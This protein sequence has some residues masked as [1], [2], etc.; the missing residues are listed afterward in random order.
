MIGNDIVRF[1]RRD[2]TGLVKLPWVLVR[3]SAYEA[4]LQQITEGEND[5]HP[6]II[7]TWDDT[8]LNYKPNQLVEK[9]DDIFIIHTHTVGDWDATTK[10]LIEPRFAVVP[11]FV[12][13]KE[14]DQE[15]LVWYDDKMWINLDHVAG[16]WQE[17]Y[18]IQAQ[19]DLLLT[20]ITFYP[21][22]GSA[23]N[24]PFTENGYIVSVG[25]DMEPVMPPAL[26][27]PTTIDV[28]EQ[29]A[30][31][32]YAHFDFSDKTT[33]F[34]DTAK[35]IPV[36]ADGDQ[37][38]VAVSVSHDSEN[39]HE[40]TTTDPSGFFATYKEDGSG[41]GYLDFDRKGDVDLDIHVPW[42]S[43]LGYAGLGASVTV[44]TPSDVTNVQA[45]TRNISTMTL[46]SLN[47]QID[48]VAGL[49]HGYDAIAKAYDNTITTD[50]TEFFKGSDSVYWEIFSGWDVSQVEHF[51]YLFEDS[52]ADM[53][54]STW[55]M[56]NAITAEGMLKNASSFDSPLPVINAPNLESI[57]YFAQ[58]ASSLNQSVDNWNMPA[59]TNAESAFQ[60][61]S[62]F[63]QSL[64]T[65][66][67]GALININCFFKNASAFNS[68]IVNGLSGPITALNETFMNAQSFNQDISGIPTA[69]ITSL[70]STL[71][72]AQAFNQSIDFIDMKGVT[73][74][75]DMLNGAVIFDQPFTFD[76]HDLL[77]ADRAFKDT[78]AFNQDLSWW[79][80]GN[81]SVTDILEGSGIDVA[82]HPKFG[83][84]Y[85]YGLFDFSNSAAMWQDEAKTLPATVHGDP[86]MVVDSTVTGVELRA[87]DVG[88]PP[89]ITN[90]KDIVQQDV[91]LNISVDDESVAMLVFTKLLPANYLEY[92]VDYGETWTSLFDSDIVMDGDG[93]TLGSDYMIAW[94]ANV[95][96]AIDAKTYPSELTVT[97]T[98]DAIDTA[99]L[100]VTGMGMNVRIRKNDSQTFTFDSQ[101]D[102]QGGAVLNG[103]ISPTAPVDA[104]GLAFVQITSTQN[105]ALYKDD[106]E[107]TT[108]V[109]TVILPGV[110]Y[111]HGE[112]AMD[113]VDVNESRPVHKVM[114]HALVDPAQ[115]ADIQSTAVVQTTAVSPSVSLSFENLYM[116]V[117]MAGVT[118]NY[119]DWDVKH[120]HTMD[121]AFNTPSM[122]DE[123]L[124]GWNVSL[125]DPDLVTTPTNVGGG[126]I[127]AL[128]MPQWGEYN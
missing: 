103:S 34:Q 15:D 21:N 37:V 108:W 78:T 42:Q 64:E 26:G 92:S 30:K 49:A 29:V 56:S 83:F 107:I 128:R 91:S 11:D 123:N 31:E 125:W 127:T 122:T 118:G 25:T 27:Q 120:V 68:P 4:V 90:G 2:D 109:P 126:N 39:P 7:P 116:G 106:S 114:A 58:G 104:T 51:D 20:D 100:S 23:S 98:L 35:T 74:I 80:T 3:Q 53:D 119:V 96:S 75:S 52:T 62:A 19:A 61:A 111:T 55:D 60:G 43:V 82:N 63:D 121:N 45:S 93:V 71:Q 86:V 89:V 115:I 117:D 14:Y 73:D 65:W 33:L 81:T 32:P 102:N 105:F 41:Q 79:H 48:W 124:S 50:L 110:G 69:D 70:V 88:N 95:Q 57:A 99:T 40:L 16:P 94:V 84:G 77:T 112:N 101:P 17:S 22:A 28:Y 13:G 66:V 12:E 18:W 38:A 8:H 24:T 113:V 44:V 76:F 6:A 87:A 85:D 36:V 72:G 1:Y 47:E 54:L 97:V 67:T 46:L 59:L 10:T 9:D 5:I